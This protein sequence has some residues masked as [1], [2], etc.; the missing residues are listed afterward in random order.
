MFI[1][2]TPFPTIGNITYSWWDE[3]LQQ[4]QRAVD[5]WSGGLRVFGGHL[6]PGKGY[7]YPIL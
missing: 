3:V 7:W 6:N 2:D 5:D 1:N 4:H